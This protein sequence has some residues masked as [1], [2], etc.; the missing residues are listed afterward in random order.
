MKVGF[1]QINPTVGDLAG[2]AEK[3]LA[4]YRH[5]VKHGAEVV[6]APEICIAGYPPRDLLFQSRFVPA[7]LEA[8]GKLEREI[9]DVPLVV[10]FVEPRSKKLPGQSFYNSAALLQRGRERRVV[11]KSLLPTYD[12]FDEARYF[13]P[14]DST[15]PVEINGRR[16]GITI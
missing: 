7:Q 10:G 16:V 12:V 13:E 4:A 11:R 15:A 9:E 2:N 3:V 1:A 5:A 8:V 14:A 6:L